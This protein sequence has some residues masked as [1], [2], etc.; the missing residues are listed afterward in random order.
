MYNLD[1]SSDEGYLLEVAV[2]YFKKLHELHNILS[3]LTER[4]KTEK[5]E[6]LVVNLHDK[7][8]YVIDI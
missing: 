3:L 4:M 1:R 8:K 5:V 6:K 2:Q 7:T